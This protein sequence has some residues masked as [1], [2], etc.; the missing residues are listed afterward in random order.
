MTEGL[1]QNQAVV[2]A[3]RSESVAPAQKTFT[4]D[5]LN[6]IVS[7][8]LADERRSHAQQEV[9][10]QKQVGISPEELEALVEKKA[11]EKLE[12]KL[13]HKLKAIQDQNYVQ[14]L[15]M[16]HNLTKEAGR[17][18]YGDDFDAVVNT[19]DFGNSTELVPLIQAMP[20][21]EDVMYHLGKE[22]ERF[23]A[24]NLALKTKQFQKAESLMKKFSDSIMANEKS[25]EEAKK[26]PKTNK[27]LS[28]LKPSTT[29]VD[30]MNMSLRD[31]KSL[32]K[33]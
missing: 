9:V 15:V 8:R 11:D 25:A 32:L 13:D 5:E 27:P 31:L 21:K 18:K 14:S 28:Q 29:G 4:Q 7:K 26:I 3:A 24:I 17:K 20:N 33:R 6:Y 12:Q 1:N 22:D 19:I 10:Q 30:G 23:M 16:Q 2:D